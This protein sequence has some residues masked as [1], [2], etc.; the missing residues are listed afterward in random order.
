M[1]RALAHT[2]AESA[3][4]A[5]AVL[6]LPRHNFPELSDANSAFW[7]AV[8]ERAGLAKPAAYTA[9]IPWNELTLAQVC[10]YGF[11]TQWA[12]RSRLVATP[13]YRARGSDGPFLRSAVLVRDN[14][15]AQGL[16]DLRGR[17]CAYDL[18]DSASRNLLRAETA[19]L[20]RDG[21]FFGRMASD[22]GPLSAVNRVVQG[23]AD[24]VLIDGAAL[25]HV[26]R[27]HSTL[28]S[29]LRLI[30]WT[31]RGPGPPLV[32]SALAS[33]ADVLSLRNALA[34]AVADPALAPE[35]AELLIRDVHPLPESQYRAL[36]HFE[37]MAQSQGYPELK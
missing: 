35:R 18:D 29:K 26:Q 5:T 27:L 23:E 22:A 21:G 14:D 32:T 37:Q 11:V 19:V 31:A 12:A 30:L 2:A 7:G 25:A 33:S 16:T 13:S 36:L 6:G 15:P 20:S 10:A 3:A 9:S 24:A 8:I 1:S 4:P 17:T 34:D 28:A